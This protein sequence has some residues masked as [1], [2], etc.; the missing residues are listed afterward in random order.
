MNF[1]SSNYLTAS[2]QLIWYLIKSY[3]RFIDSLVTALLIKILRT[4]FIFFSVIQSLH[5]KLP[6][7]LSRCHQLIV[8]SRMDPLFF[9]FSNYFI[10]HKLFLYPR[11]LFLHFNRK[12]FWCRP[13][14]FLFHFTNKGSRVQWQQFYYRLIGGKKNWMKER[15][16]AGEQGASNVIKGLRAL[17]AQ[18]YGRW[19]NF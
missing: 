14:V 6:L 17:C 11:Q 12:F 13:K 4:W 19:I 7:F 18:K 5:W 8:P 15:R 10:F 3:Y 9:Y 2:Y 1:I 16:H